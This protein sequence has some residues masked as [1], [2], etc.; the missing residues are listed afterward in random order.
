[1]AAGIAFLCIKIIVAIKY[2]LV[3]KLDTHQLCCVLL[4]LECEISNNTDTSPHVHVHFYYYII[5]N[6][7]GVGKSS[8][9]ATWSLKI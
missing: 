5:F 6:T 9:V 7:D 4:L 8:L 3:A 1:M 2:D